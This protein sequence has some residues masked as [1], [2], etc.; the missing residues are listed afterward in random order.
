MQGGRDIVSG[1]FHPMKYKSL[2]HEGSLGQF[3]SK[4]E[5]CSVTIILGN[6]YSKPKEI[7]Q[8]QK[9]SYLRKKSHA[10]S[11]V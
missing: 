6:K 3:Y 11:L 10:T 5:I 1:S 2:L 9:V 4:K 8:L 7:I